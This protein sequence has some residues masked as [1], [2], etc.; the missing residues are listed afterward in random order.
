[1][2]VRGV[3]GKSSL[4]IYELWTKKWGVPLYK[5]AKAS[6]HFCKILRFLRFD[7]NSSHRTNENLIVDSK[8][9]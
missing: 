3:T 4:L 9:L 6:N 1:M 5:E 2:F 7:L 8:N